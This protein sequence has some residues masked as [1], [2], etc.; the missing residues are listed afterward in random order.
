[1]YVCSPFLD[2]ALSG[3]KVKDKSSRVKNDTPERP[4]RST[5]KLSK[6]LR[7]IPSG[8]AKR[9]CHLLKQEVCNRYRPW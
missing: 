4:R 8:A 9:V 2:A 3:P 1:M 5:E 7:M 6:I